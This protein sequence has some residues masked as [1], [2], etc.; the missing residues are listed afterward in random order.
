MNILTQ[1]ILKTI[2]VNDGIIHELSKNI[3]DD[4]MINNNISIKIK[5]GAYSFTAPKLKQYKCCLDNNDNIKCAI[6][7]S[8]HSGIISHKRFELQKHNKIHIP[9]GT[10]ED[11][12][13][14]VILS[15]VIINCSQNS[16]FVEYFKGYY[17]M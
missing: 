3:Y 5:N 4:C 16:Y 1:K 11:L 12:A 7:F 10:K 8:Q 2:F 9:N 15:N 17:Q 14:G 13:W 6:I